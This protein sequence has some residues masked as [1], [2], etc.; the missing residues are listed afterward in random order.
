MA[1]VLEAPRADRAFERLY[2]RH[3]T[4]VYRYVL[5][6]LQ[7]E[8]DAEDATQTTFLSAYRAFERGQRPDRPHNWLIA[9]AHNVCRQRFRESARRPRL[10]ELED[11]VPAAREVDD[12]TPNAEDIRRALGYLAFNQRAALVMRELQGRSYGEIADILGVSNGAVETL[13]FRARRAMREQLE[14]GLSCG[15]AELAL[16]KRVD[17]ELSFGERGA[18]RAHLRECAECAALERRLRFRGRALKKIALVPLPQ[19]LGSLF[20]GGAA[21]TGAAVGTKAAAVVVAGVF[22]TGLAGDAIEETKGAREQRTVVATAPRD[23]LSSGA[24]VVAHGTGAGPPPAS[25][26]APAR[27]LQRRTASTPTRPAAS[28][29]VRPSARTG[30]RAGA[31]PSVAPSARPRPA[32][33]VAAESSQPH[34]AGTTAGPPTERGRPEKTPRGRPV[35]ER[36][37]SR[38]AH[39]VPKRSDHPRVVELPKVRDL[40]KLPKL[41][42]PVD[43]P[44]RPELPGPPELPNPP[45]ISRAADVPKPPEL[46]K[47]PEVPKPP[48]L[49][50]APNPPQLPKPPE[51]PNP[52]ELPKPPEV[53]TLP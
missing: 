42:K 11:D 47:P 41:P 32:D 12:G 4:D 48:D 28:T 46:P 29:P 13:L 44:K 21:G 40:P 2:R 7:N 45:E 37:V 27:A 5:A 10:V 30:A 31:S 20:G 9:I 52:P 49:P 39:P 8:A 34:D 53:P 6:I 24:G 16:S 25:R 19:S 1:T 36:P 26:L 18:L 14:G 35:R 51:L 43:L 50:K 23:V 3:V 15:D 38:P 22:G 17:G 33:S